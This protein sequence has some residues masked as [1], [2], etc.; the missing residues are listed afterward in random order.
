MKDIHNIII[1]YLDDSATLEEKQFL[2][3]WLKE[4][5]E[6][7]KEF[8][9]IR[10]LWIGVN[11]TIGEI[12]L[13][14]ALKKFR[15]R[16]FE[17]LDEKGKNKKNRLILFL[18]IAALFLLAFGLN[19]LFFHKTTETEYKTEIINRLITSENGKGRFLLPDSTIVWLNKNSSLEYPEKFEANFR[20]VKL[21]GEAYFQV[22][23]DP[24]KE[25]IVDASDIRV[26]VTGTSFVV[27]NYENRKAIETILLNGGVSVEKNDQPPVGLSPNQRYSLEKGSESISIDSVNAL[28]Y[29]G[30]IEKRLQ[31]D[32][33]KLSDI[34]TQMSEWYG[35]DIICTRTYATQP[36][37]TLMIRDESIDEI[38]K[39]IQMIEPFRYW[40]E[41]QTLYI[42][43]G[44]Q[45]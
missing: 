25:F 11:V 37:M 36:N 39:A 5:E 22:Y 21:Q 35:I 45:K 32:N 44:E 23:K 18:R 19:Y 8:Q 3:D 10:D 1:H 30:W 41:E 17:S 33:A 42:T 34:L 16:I 31:F 7:R 2:L 28:N 27:Q 29:I 12:E 26:K 43:P 4:S 13:E 20:Q 24:D 9:E 40:W 38:L 6:N 15:K 14:N